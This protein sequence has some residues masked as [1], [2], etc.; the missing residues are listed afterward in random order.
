LLKGICKSFFSGRLK[1]KNQS[2]PQSC[3]IKKTRPDLPLPGRRPKDQM[4]MKHKTIDYGTR[5][6]ENFNSG[7]TQATNSF[8]KKLLIFIKFANFEEIFRYQ[9]VITAVHGF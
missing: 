1:G 9:V 7:S 2:F 3:A 6:A 4:T 5:S 8:K